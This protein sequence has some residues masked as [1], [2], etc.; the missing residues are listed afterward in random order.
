M[1]S[2]LRIPR[3]EVFWGDYNLS[4]Y[5]GG[6]VDSSHP[7]YGEPLVYNVSVSLNENSQTPTGSMSWNP[8]GVAYQV[9]ENLVKNH[10]NR[11]ITV[12]FYYL[13]GRSITFAFVWSGQQE[14]YGQSMDLKVMLSSEL[15]GLIN[16]TVGNTAV[17]DPQGQSMKG[18]MSEIEKSFGLGK[19]KLID[20]AG[21]TGKD[22]EKSKVLENYNPG[23]KFY[24]SVAGLAD[25]NGNVVFASNIVSSKDTAQPAAK[26]IMFA[27]YIWEKDIE[28]KELSPTEQF[29]SPKE[30][31][32]YFLGPC[33][34]DTISKQSQW[35]LPQKR[36]TLTFTDQQ[37]L[38]PPTPP[39]GTTPATQANSIQTVPQ[40]GATAAAQAA[41]TQTNS[42]G[43][44]RSSSRSRMRL[45]DNEDGE[46]KKVLLEEQRQCRMNT[47]L[48]MSPAFTGIKP[49][50]VMFIPNFGGTFMEDWVV[51][52]VEY[53]QT[54][55][56]VNLSVQAS[57]KFALGDFMNPSQGKIWL[58]KAKAYGLV[59]EGATLENWMNYGW[60]PGTGAA[61]RAQSSQVSGG[62]AEPGSIVNQQIS[63]FVPSAGNIG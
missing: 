52:S 1:A 39:T 56:G 29:P 7:L 27:P 19:Y 63:G 23:M 47:T 20:F 34:I 12:R 45:K 25:N 14:N 2:S 40:Q 26:C 48:F 35:Q 13:D 33:L 54:D 44:S 55:G 41:R 43:V 24:D 28:V 57:R 62:R 4:S 59:G 61:G 6:N 8:T 21:S 22:L 53:T 5:S 17:T 3:V 58:N 16:G 50:D 31:Y 46:E 51:T 10:A 42:A 37:K 36:Q 11:I 49:H 38:Q 15:D 30:R 60:K 32:G 18:A 9:Y